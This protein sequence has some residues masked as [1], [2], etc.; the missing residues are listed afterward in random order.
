MLQQ[1]VSV[2]DALR[3]TEELD[4]QHC[5]VI[6][7]RRGPD[8]IVDGLV[9]DGHLLAGRFAGNGP[10]GCQ[11]PFFAEEFFPGVL[12]L[13]QSVGVQ[14]QGR[15]RRDHEF[16]LGV[17]HLFVDADR[18]VRSHI[19]LPDALF[20]QQQGCIVPGVAIAQQAG[21]QVQRSDE[22]GNEHIALVVLRHRFVHL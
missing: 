16:L 11:E 12:G 14:E 10:G 7:L 15:A 17:T 20:G 1:E 21:G 2:G 13:G 3:I 9:D 6:A 18:A 22:E 4:A 5:E 8:E 19:D